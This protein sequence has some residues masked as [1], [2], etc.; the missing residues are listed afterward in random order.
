M[1]ANGEPTRLPTASSG[2]P[3]TVVARIVP[4]PSGA[5]HEPNTMTRSQFRRQ[6]SESTLPRYSN[7]TPRPIRPSSTKSTSRYVPESS[8][9]Y[10]PGNAAKVAATATITQTS[11]PSHTGP[12]VLIMTRRSA[13]SCA[14][15]GSSIPTPKSKPSRNR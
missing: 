4:T 2:R 1:A 14:S 7:A 9:A 8:P 5:T 11:L 12:M 10:Q 3:S 13:L 15:S 6:R